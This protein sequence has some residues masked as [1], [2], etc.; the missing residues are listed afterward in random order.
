MGIK[1]ISKRKVPESKEEVIMPL[2]NQLRALAQKQPGFNSEETWRRVDYPDEYLVVRQWDSE[3]D[4]G[5]WLTNKERVKIRD[6][7]EKQLGEHTEYISYEIIHRIEK[8][9]SIFRSI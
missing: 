6:Q 1:I 9:I 5:L 8:P 2:I 3:D 4:W 7:I